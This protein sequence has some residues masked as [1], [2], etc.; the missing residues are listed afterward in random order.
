MNIAMTTMSLGSWSD[1]G[2]AIERA[3]GSI[4]TLFGHLLGFITDKEIYRSIMDAVPDGVKSAVSATALSLLTL[5]FFIG[6]LGKTLNL[7]WVTWENVLMLFL[8]LVIAKICVD[9][10]AWIMDKTQNAFASLVQSVSFGGE[11][12]TED[13]EEESVSSVTG[14]I[15]DLYKEYANTPQFIDTTKKTDVLL[16]AYVGHKFLWFGKKY[17]KDILSVPDKYFYFLDTYDAAAA[18]AAY[19]DIVDVKAQ[20]TDLSPVFAYMGVFINSLLIKA[21]LVIALVMMISRYMWLAVYTVAAPLSLATFAS[22]ETKDIG[23]SFIKSYI[24]VCL[25]ATVLVIICVA[26]GA[27]STTITHVPALG[28]FVGLIK[29]FAFGGMVMKSESVAN[30]LCGAM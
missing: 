19:N 14:W 17:E 26:F 30:K 18:Y 16:T 9:N 21:V 10:S 13:D 25:H 5:I 11:E 24:G 1:V 15:Y 28:G 6:F 3:V 12:E 27:V 29:T 23:K 2:G 20:V 4:N 22:D 7:Q 8:Q